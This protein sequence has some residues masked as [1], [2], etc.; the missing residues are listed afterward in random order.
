MIKY[1]AKFSS[2][3]NFQNK[4]V[5]WSQKNLSKPVN[6]S[7][8]NTVSLEKYYFLDTIK[9]LSVSLQLENTLI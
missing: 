2:A 3:D 8:Y 6:W 1:F 9:W 5:I 4:D 7:K